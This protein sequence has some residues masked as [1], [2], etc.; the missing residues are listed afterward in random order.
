M[1]KLSLSDQKEG[2]SM[3]RKWLVTFLAPILALSIIT[4]CGT[5]NNTPVRDNAPLDQND[6]R[7]LNN[8]GNLDRGTDN[9][10]LRDDNIQDDNLRDNRDNRDDNLND[11][12]VNQGTNNR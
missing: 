7:D 6:N 10:N 2:N 1:V 4:G 9:N 5:T 8:D 12:G 3:K 11:D